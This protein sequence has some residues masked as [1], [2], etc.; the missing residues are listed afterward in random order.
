MATTKSA[1]DTPVYQIKVTLEGSKPPI[2]RRLLVPGDI[3]LAD[4]HRHH[5]GGV[6][7]VGLSSSPVYHRRD[8][9][10]RTPPRL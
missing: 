4:L 7:L 10:W 1:T 8:L 6:R 2:W 5:P 9:L 3:T